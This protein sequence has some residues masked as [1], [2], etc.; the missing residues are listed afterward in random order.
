M[1]KDKKITNK[2]ELQMQDTKKK[3]TLFK[4]YSWF[5]EVEF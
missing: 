2:T 1:F 5:C 4:S 3:E